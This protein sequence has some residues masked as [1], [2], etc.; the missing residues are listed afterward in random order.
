MTARPAPTLAN[1][2]PFPT[3]DSE[4]ARAASGVNA[5]GES[6][7]TDLH[8]TSEADTP[9]L[10]AVVATNGANGYL[11]NSELMAAEPAPTSPDE[12]IPTP[13]VD[14]LPVYRSDGV[15]VIGY[16]DVGQ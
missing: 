2:R 11:R 8:S 7:G 14:W 6:Y 16:F 10:I 3:E 5:R 13:T 12:P 9:D 4:G 1:G 15:T